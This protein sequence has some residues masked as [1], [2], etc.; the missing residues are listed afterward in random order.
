M[1]E[2]LSVHVYVAPMRPFVGASGDAGD[3]PM[4]SPMSSTLIAGEDDAILVDALVANE[5]VDDLAE[6]ARGFGKRVVGVYI[7]HG[8]ADHWM[9]L[10][11][12]QEQFP[13][14]KGI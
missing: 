8:H 12:L 14:A 10:A 1:S 4:W 5:Q 7:T 9:G 11:K 13:D 3:R 6:W 2:S